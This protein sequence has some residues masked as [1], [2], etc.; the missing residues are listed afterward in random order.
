MATESSVLLYS[1]C[2]HRAQS[3]WAGGL[4]WKNIFVAEKETVAENF[5]PDE[6]EF[7]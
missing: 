5:L 1:V 3:N 6:K 2:L 4:S 7:E